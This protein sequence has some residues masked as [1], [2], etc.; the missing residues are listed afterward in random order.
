MKIILHA[1]KVRFLINGMREQGWQHIKQGRYKIP[2]NA[3]N[4]F[5]RTKNKDRI[6]INHTNFRLLK[7]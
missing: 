3:C 1:G 5:I 4:S 7:W 6:E 2:R